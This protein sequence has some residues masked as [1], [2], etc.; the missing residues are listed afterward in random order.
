[1]KSV[2]LPALELHHKEH[3]IVLSRERV[4]KGTKRMNSL[5]LSP[6]VISYATL[7]RKPLL[8]SPT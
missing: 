4:N 8:T 1:M 3:T 7:Q 6:V 5:P 2:N